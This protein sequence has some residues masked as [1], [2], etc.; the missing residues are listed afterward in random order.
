[1]WTSKTIPLPGIDAVKR[2]ADEMEEKHGD[3]EVDYPAAGYRTDIFQL[4]GIIRGL[5]MAVDS[6]VLRGQ[7]NTND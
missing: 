3:D 6:H 5:M 4:L 2:I 1:M 7:D